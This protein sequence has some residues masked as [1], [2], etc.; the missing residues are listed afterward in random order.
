MLKHG[1][2]NFVFMGRSGTSKVAA[3]NL[4]AD[5]RAAGADVEV[6]QGDVAS[7]ADVERAVMT[8]KRPIGGIVQAAMSIHVSSTYI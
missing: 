1:A 8:A 4:V 7:Y 6:V 3:R 5:L 2:R